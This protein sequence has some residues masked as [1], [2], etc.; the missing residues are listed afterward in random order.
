[1]PAD[2]I[3]P[4]EPGCA[5]AVRLAA[6]QPGACG[7]EPVGTVEH[8]YCYPRPH[9]ARLFVCAEHSQGLEVRALDDADRTELDR[10]RRERAEAYGRRAANQS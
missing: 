10:R 9:V 4:G 7:G 1:M 8:R 2:L 6:G 3:Y 5:A